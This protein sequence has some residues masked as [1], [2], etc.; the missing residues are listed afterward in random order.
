M[1]TENILRSIDIKIGALIALQ[2]VEDKPETN[3]QKIKLLSE[4]GLGNGDIASILNVSN[5]YIAKEKSLI[6]RKNG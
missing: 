4:L 5:K 6:K 1:S 2:M 3:R